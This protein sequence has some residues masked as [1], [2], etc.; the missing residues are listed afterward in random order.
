[1]L[2]PPHV[3]RLHRELADVAGQAK[4]GWHAYL[5]FVELGAG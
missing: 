3:E 1:M 2:S 4:Y 5:V